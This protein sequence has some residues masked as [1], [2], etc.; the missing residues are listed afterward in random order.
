MIPS[1]P[2]C[3]RFSERPRSD[4]I[5]T[6]QLP[7]AATRPSTSDAAGGCGLIERLLFSSLALLASDLISFMAVAVCGFL[8]CVLELWSV[9]SGFEFLKHTFFYFL[10]VFLFCIVSLGAE[11]MA[12]VLQFF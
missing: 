2:V 4:L 7:P 1:K 12:V 8:F 9:G 10:V 11:V 5:S 3:L 6:N